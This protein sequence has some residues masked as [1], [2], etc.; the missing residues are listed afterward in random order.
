MTDRRMPVRYRRL[1]ILTRL[2]QRLVSG[3]SLEQLHHL[4]TPEINSAVDGDGALVLVREGESWVASGSAGLGQQLTGAVRLGRDIATQVRKKG[5][6]LRTEDDRAGSRDLLA[7]RND[8]PPWCK[9]LAAPLRSEVESKRADG[10]LIVGSRRAAHFDEDDEL[11]LETITTSLSNAICLWRYTAR[12]DAPP[13]AR[14]HRWADSHTGADSHLHLA[15]ALTEELAYAGQ[16]QQPLSLALIDVDRLEEVNSMF[17]LPSG[18]AVLLEVVHRLCSLGRGTA[19]RV[20]GGTFA[21]LLP[22]TD[23]ASAH[24]IAEQL[25][26]VVASDLFAVRDAEV[27]VT[28]SVGVATLADDT[29]DGADL[30]ARAAS[31]LFRAKNEGRSRV[32][33]AD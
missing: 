22:S 19:A 30:V 16:H 9:V 11:L 2:Y 15:R 28:A 31:A 13:E 7:Y 18:D 21:M 25:R 26:G 27:V 5:G 32:V 4:L 12:G 29:R 24:G 10:A 1:P 17:G 14:E 23:R 6:L 33:S 3:A 20:D 8:Q